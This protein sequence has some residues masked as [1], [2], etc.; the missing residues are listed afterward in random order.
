MKLFNKLK[1]VLNMETDQSEISKQQI[2]ENPIIDDKNNIDYLEY[3]AEV[4]GYTSRQEQYFCYDQVSKYIL[5]GDSIIDF[6]AGRGDYYTYYL[7]R[8]QEEPNYLGLDL[9][10]QLITAGRKVNGNVNLEHTNWLN[11][12]STDNYK[13]DW[14]INVGSVN[15]RYDTNTSSNEEY[16]LKTIDKMM[17]CCNKG[18]IL[19]FA[20]TMLPEEYKQAG[21]I[22]TNPGK[23][24]NHVLEI[25]GKESGKIFL[26]H[27]FSNAA[28]LL[29]LGK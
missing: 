12:P 17:A 11:I 4:V 2:V 19:L 10:Q 8:S 29:V 26:D 14:A 16:L 1:K 15:I 18:S 6:G 21:Y 7:N 22:L 28:F 9:N 5:V 3:S 24:L 23:I 25:Y 13:K 27:S 20:S